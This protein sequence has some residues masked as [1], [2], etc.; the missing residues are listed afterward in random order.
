[1]SLNRIT[2]FTAEFPPQPGGIGNHAYNLAKGLK[3]KGYHV[4]VLCDRRSED[5]EEER[6][7]DASFDFEVIRIPRRKLMLSSYLHRI[8]EAYKLAKKSEVF[9]ASGK[10]QLWMGG[11]LSLLLKNR[12]IA[13]IHGSELLLPNK[14]LRKLTYLALGKFDKVIAVSNYTRS[15][16]ASLA[17]E[18]VEVI[19]NG[20]SMY[21]D[22]DEKK[23]KPLSPILV[24]V[25][26]VTQRKGQHNI[27][28]ALPLL[29]KEYPD[30]QYR[31]IG[32]PTERN[33]LQEQAKDLKVE[34]TVQFYGAVQDTEKCKLLLTSNIFMM[35]S[36][37]TNTG[38]VEGFGIAILEANY[39]GIPSI[40]A[41][42][43]GIEEAIK[44]GYSGFLV[45]NKEPE[46]ILTSIAHIMENYEEF[47]QNARKWSAC[48]SW[49]RV[50][51]R[52][53]EIIENK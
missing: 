46:E 51:N 4:M 15:L 34:K 44:D 45:N 26:N 41:K 25:G 43:C 50:I 27:I 5:G 32:I 28:A 53:V 2:I 20:F 16:I 42:G 33:K 29:L 37:T 48:F 52:Y 10:F 19:H 35:L 23:E 24:T 6:V 11:F 49:D 40:G 22:G 1:M 36:E 7:F 8:L 39:L 17:L 30:L 31:V 47:S 18:K 12:Y 3:K 21:C 38:D 14:F 9:I 13:V